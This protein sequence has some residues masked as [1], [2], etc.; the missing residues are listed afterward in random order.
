MSYNN[1]FASSLC[2]DLVYPKTMIGFKEGESFPQ[3]NDRA[4]PEMPAAGN[5]DDN[6]ENPH[7]IVD[8]LK[9]G[10]KITHVRI[11]GIWEDDHEMCFNTIC[12]L[13]DGTKYGVSCWWIASECLVE[14]FDS[15]QNAETMMNYI[16]E[17]A[18]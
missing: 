10:K 13:D 14:F 9:N 7:P 15:A 12:T 3:P 8:Q 11:C 16:I 4:F 2:D 6:G 18:E 17:S 5:D 1:F